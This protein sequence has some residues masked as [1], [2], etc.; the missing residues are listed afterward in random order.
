MKELVSSAFESVVEPARPGRQLAAARESCGFTIADIARQLKLSPLQVAAIEADD[1]QHLPG[2]VFVRG[3]IRNYARLVKLDPAALLTGTTQQSPAVTLPQSLPQSELPHALSI[4]FSTR[5]EF[6]RHKYAIG[7]LLALALLAMY[8]FYRDDAADITEKS[9]PIPLL[10]PEIVAPEKVAQASSVPQPAALSEVA[11]KS[12]RTVTAAQTHKDAGSN[13]E[14]LGKAAS[15][16]HQSAEHLLKLRFDRESWVEIRDRNG[17]RIFSQLNPAGTEMAVSGLPPLSLVVGNA[18]GV[19]LTHND[20]PVNL[21]PH[22]KIDVAR[23][24]LE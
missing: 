11:V 6:R 21:A 23:L 15:V 1:N 2:A 19:Q 4:P 17:R 18:A 22:I 5:R 12:A 10:Q 16:E 8:E 24:T 9:R 13:A 3:F 14:Q 7:A 20:Q